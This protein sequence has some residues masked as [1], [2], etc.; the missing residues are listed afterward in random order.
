MAIKNCKQGTQNVALEKLFNS[1]YYL[2]VLMTNF[3]TRSGP[4]AEK[5]EKSDFFGKLLRNI[6]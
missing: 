5:W 3:C 2:K 4:K 6:K 1:R